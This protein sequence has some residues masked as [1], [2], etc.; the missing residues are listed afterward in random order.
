MTQGCKVDGASLHGGSPGVEVIHGPLHDGFLQRQVGAV[1][2]AVLG[3]LVACNQSLLKRGLCWG[4]G[5]ENVRSD[6]MLI[7]MDS[8][9]TALACFRQISR[10]DVVHLKLTLKLKI[11]F[12]F[13]Y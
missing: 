6:V 7:L 10:V 5:E 9:C 11:F 8:C 2:T 1:Q 3:Q 4:Q 13:F 12:F